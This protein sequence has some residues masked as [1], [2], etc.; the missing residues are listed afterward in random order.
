[1][2]VATETVNF[3]SVITFIAQEKIIDESLAKFW[4]DFTFLSAR[5][6]KLGK[7]ANIC[8]HACP[9]WAKSPTFVDMLAQ[10]GQSRQHLWTC[11][12]KLGKAANICG[13]ACPN[14]AKPPT[15]VDMLAQI[16]QSRQQL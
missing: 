2:T 14:R 16:G 7:A 10:I 13:H 4:Q 6:P 8:G 1:M 9:N 12:P 11:L 15:F 5:L 3:D